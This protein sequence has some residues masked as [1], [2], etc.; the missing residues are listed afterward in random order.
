MQKKTKKD[1][2]TMGVFDKIKN[3]F[4]EEEEI[5]V[6]IKKEVKHV[7]ITPPKREVEPIRPKV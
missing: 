6:P 2:E 7:E 4:T 3:L 5:E 1:G